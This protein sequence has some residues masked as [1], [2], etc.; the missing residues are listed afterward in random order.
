MTKSIWRRLGRVSF[1]VTWPFWFMYLRKGKRT[2]VIIT[3]GDKVVVTRAWLGDGKW[4]L[5]GGGIHNGEQAADGAIREVREE[6]GLLLKP[7]QLKYLGSDHSSKS[8][9]RFNFE[10][11]I[12]YL[13]EQL[14]VKADGLENAEARWMNLDKLGPDN[15][16]LA[17]LATITR[18]QSKVASPEYT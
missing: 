9:L 14:S 3:C 18:W 8:G 6:T 10:Q 11:F 2:R 4:S 17:S 16:E 7:I 15:L 13:D 5:P 12:V 1:W